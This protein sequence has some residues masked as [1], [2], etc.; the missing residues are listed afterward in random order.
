MRS[1]ECVR[2]SGPL[3]PRYPGH[4]RKRVRRVGGAPVANA[5]SAEG[6]Q[7]IGGEVPGLGGGMRSRQ[8]ELQELP[9]VDGLAAGAQEPVLEIV[10]AFGLVRRA[11]PVGRRDGR[12]LVDGGR[13]RI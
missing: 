12:K 1:R 5:V 6:V 10:A 8:R 13:G 7:Q 2:Q 11:R 9:V 3:Q 4:G